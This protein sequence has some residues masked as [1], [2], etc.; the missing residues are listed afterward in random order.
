MN[1]FKDTK[2]HWFTVGIF[3]ELSSNPNTVLYTLEEARQ[4]YLECNDITGYTF[5]TTFLGGWKHWLALHNSP[6]VEPLIREW[7]EELEVKLRS[8]AV[9]NIIDLAKG[10]KGYQASKYLADRGWKIR[11]AGRPSKEEVK[12]ETRVQA[13][14]YSEFDNVVGLSKKE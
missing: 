4:F 7:E 14:M 2:G 5:S 13:K 6:K 3:K 10:D 9:Q 11:D 8:K 12:R 1:K